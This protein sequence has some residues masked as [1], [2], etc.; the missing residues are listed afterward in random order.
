MEMVANA[1][2]LPIAAMSTG[3]SFSPALAVTTG[4]SPPPLPPRPPRPPP[5]VAPA[6]EVLLLQ[7]A[8]TAAKHAATPY[9]RTPLRT[10]S[11]VTVGV[12]MVLTLAYERYYATFTS[13]TSFDVSLRDLHEATRNRA[14]KGRRAIRGRQGREELN[15]TRRLQ[16]SEPRMLFSCP[17]YV[18]SARRPFAVNRYSVLGTRP[19]N[20]F[21]L[22]TYPADSSLRAC[23]P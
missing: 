1:S 20:D 15:G 11:P 19:S 12:V 10:S 16:P 17:R 18:P 13:R 23:R 8:D 22:A 5:G 6:A 14:G 21:V 7:A 9:I 3:T 2:T 4:A